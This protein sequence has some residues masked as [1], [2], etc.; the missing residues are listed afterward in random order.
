MALANVSFYYTWRNIKSAFN[1][2]KFKI[3][4]S[5]WNDKFDL[6]DKKYSVSDI[7][8]YFVFIIKK[9]DAIADNPLLQ[10]YVIQIKSRIVFKIRTGYK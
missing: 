5:T 9:H 2:N 3:S 7:Q 1:N 10:I 8:E 4:V 6:P